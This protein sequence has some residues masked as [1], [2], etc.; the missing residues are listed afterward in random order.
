MENHSCPECNF[1]S[2]WAYNVNRH[3]MRKH[4]D[5]DTPNNQINNLSNQINNL[6]NQINNPNN[7]INNPSNQINNP[8]NLKTNQCEKCEKILSNQQ[9]YKRHCKTCKGK[10][11]KLQCDI[12]NE[13]FTLSQAKYRHQKNCKVKKEEEQKVI[14]QNITNNNITNNTTNNITNNNIVIQ[15][16]AFDKETEHH[17]N[18]EFTL[19]CFESACWGIIKMI[20]KIYFD[21][22][23]PQNHNVK[24]LSLK[25]KLVEVFTEKDWETRSMK[26]ISYKM[27]RRALRKIDTAVS[28]EDIHKSDDLIHTYL[29]LN[30]ITKEKQNMVDEHIKAK[31][32]QRKNENENILLNKE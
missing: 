5:D 31:L 2:K 17:I 29:Q 21:K 24:L 13:I 1:T 3:F 18:H 9:N 14:I 16:N 28:L 10:I 8:N 32:V 19:D 12:C 26:E 7:Q 11:N 4:I 23:C 15:I 25:N 22:E 30:N 27:K 20:D 6:S